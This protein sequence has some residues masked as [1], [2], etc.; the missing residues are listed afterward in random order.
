M[1]S[2]SRAA[3]ACGLVVVAVAAT[4]AVAAAVATDDTPSREGP[5][6]FTIELPALDDQLG[7]RPLTQLADPKVDIESAGPL[8]VASSVSGTVN[9]SEA[10][11]TLDILDSRSS[12]DEIVK[13]D[14][15]EP[16]TD[17]T[18]WAVFR[19]PEGATT[20]I[21]GKVDGVLF[22]LI[23]GE[24]LTAKEAATLVASLG[25]EESK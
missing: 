15:L 10:P 6:G 1:T 8:I 23:V 19:H 21:V 5:E 4:S 3:L 20:E 2:C 9:D 18:N 16:L 24:E 22:S 25:V 17:T 14:G 11:Y 7:T 12:V 13:L